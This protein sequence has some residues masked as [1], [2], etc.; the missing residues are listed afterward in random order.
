MF[1]YLFNPLNDNI[2]A[3]EMTYILGEPLKE[4][5]KSSGGLSQTISKQMIE[6]WAAFSKYDDPNIGNEMANWT[7]FSQPN[8][9]LLKLEDEQPEIENDVRERVCLFWDR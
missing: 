5:G 1:K 2:S 3:K 8:W 6:M 9:S 4:L 7:S